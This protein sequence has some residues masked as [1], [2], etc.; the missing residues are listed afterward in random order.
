MRI[1]VAWDGSELSTLALRAAVRNFCQREDQLI[2]YHVANIGRHG[3]SPE[4]SKDA[5]ERR[6][7]SE[8]EAADDG[9]RIL[10]QRSG[11]AFEE[12]D[13]ASESLLTLHQKAR[14]EETKISHRIVEFTSLTGA[15]V[16]VMGSTGTKQESSASF[17]QVTL[18]SSA[19][20]AA[21]RAPCTVVLIRPGYKVDPKMAT[22]YMVAV[23]GSA[24]SMHALERCAEWARPERDEVVCHVFGPPSFT[25]RIEELVTARL[26][27][28]MRTRRIEYAVIPTE[29]EGSAD[30]E[31]EELA[32]AAEQCRFRQQA[33]LVFGARG[34]R[35]EEVDEEYASPVASPKGG[36]AT[37]GHV[38]AWCIKNAQCSLIIARPRADAATMG[39][40]RSRSCEAAFL[41]EQAASSQEVEMQPSPPRAL[42]Q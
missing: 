41:A 32:D 31:G 17:Q 8:L 37:L 9:L 40:E 36:A 12:V 34:K 19:H 42:S 6:L 20:L 26:Q 11:G 28:A 39:L 7:A 22:I 23:D 25:Q 1:L 30:V 5:L 27:E 16:L 15:D 13:V 14:A 2:V 3:D 4:F 35:A 24:H 18:G 10:V 29:L 21:I 38:G 33:F